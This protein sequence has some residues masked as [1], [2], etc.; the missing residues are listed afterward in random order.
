LN[1]E[2]LKHF[3]PTQAA[4]LEADASDGAIA[5]CLSQT[6]TSSGLLQPVAFYSRKLTPMEERYDISDKELLAIVESLR[7]WRVYLE[8]VTECTKVYS[9]HSNLQGFTTTK[10]LNWRQAR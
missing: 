6:D 5:G 7:H 4:L 2:V 1:V 10:V 3:N 8:G 9:N